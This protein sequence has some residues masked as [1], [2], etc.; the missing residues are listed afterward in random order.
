M[1]GDS[2]KLVEYMVNNQSKLVSDG[3]LLKYLSQ[4]YE[5]FLK[6]D[7]PSEVLLHRASESAL[8]L[9]VQI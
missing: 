7:K 9:L 8:L 5:C 3:L 2:A 6:K 4:K 1:L